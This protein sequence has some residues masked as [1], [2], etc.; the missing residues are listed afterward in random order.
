MRGIMFHTSGQHLGCFKGG[1]IVSD[2]RMEDACKRGSLGKTSF[3]K[4][5]VNLGSI[6]ICISLQQ[7]LEATLYCT[8]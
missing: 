5:L 2:S 8:W 7:V 1:N 3:S 4:V 6:G